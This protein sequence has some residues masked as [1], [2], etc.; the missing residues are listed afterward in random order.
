MTSRALS[1][2]IL[3]IT[4]LAAPNGSALASDKEARCLKSLTTSGRPHRIETIAQ[5]NAVRV[6]S[7]MAASK[8]AAYSMWHN[9]RGAQISCD[10]MERSAFIRCTAKAKPCLGMGAKPGTAQ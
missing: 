1:G 2:I 4:L 9:A 8:G 10:K 7:E 6:W 3:L 5:L